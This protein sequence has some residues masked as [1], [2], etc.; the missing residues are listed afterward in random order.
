[1]DEIHWATVSREGAKETKP[2]SSTSSTILQWS[3]SMMQIASSKQ[4][5]NDGPSAVGYTMVN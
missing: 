1:M 5:T 4:M 2:G 3:S